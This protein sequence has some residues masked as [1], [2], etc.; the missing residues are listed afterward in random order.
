MSAHDDLGGVSVRAEVAEPEQ[1]HVYS[2]HNAPIVSFDWRLP[3]KEG[4][5]MRSRG[6][7]GGVGPGWGETST[8]AAA[9]M[10]V[11]RGRRVGSGALD[12]TD[13]DIQ[14]RLVRTNACT[15]ERVNACTCERV[16]ACT[17]ER[18]NV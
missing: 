3:P 10:A 15:C 9:R 8:V 11:V 14:A 6:V 2:G 5:N 1:V 7:G 16:N 17:R 12:E 18:V 4:G 13:E